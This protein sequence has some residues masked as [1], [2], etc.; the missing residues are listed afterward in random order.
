MRNYLTTIEP[1]FVKCPNCQT[2]WIK[3]GMKCPTCY[4]DLPKQSLLTNEDIDKIVNAITK[5]LR[6]N[7]DK[8]ANLI[9]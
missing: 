3:H 5:R 7:K 1:D 8:N 2:T 6:D 9:M 4:P